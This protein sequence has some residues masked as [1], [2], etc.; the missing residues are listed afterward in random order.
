MEV[1]NVEAQYFA[2]IIIETLAVM[3]LQY[4]KAK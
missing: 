1:Q 4:T 3:Q 2:S